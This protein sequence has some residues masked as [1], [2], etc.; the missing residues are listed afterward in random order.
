MS[1]SSNPVVVIGA[2]LAGALAATLLARR[3][4]QV[5]VFERRG[6]LR[7]ST[8]SAGR[9]INLALSTRGV[10]ALSRVGLEADVLATTL[11]MYGRRMHDTDGTMTYQP[12]G[13][14]GQ[15]IHSVSRRG[16]NEA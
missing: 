2:G 9:S 14:D 15:A 4:H 5:A 12:Y 1:T 6:D 8:G 7:K 13:Q 3:G 16:L 11:P 10:A